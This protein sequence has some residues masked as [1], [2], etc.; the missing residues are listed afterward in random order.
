MLQFNLKLKN[1]NVDLLH[2][3][4]HTHARARNFYYIVSNMHDSRHLRRNDDITHKKL[5]FDKSYMFNSYANYGDKTD[6]NQLDFEVDTQY[7]LLVI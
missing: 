4:A 5:K 1:K 2:T 6:I 7:I 3:D